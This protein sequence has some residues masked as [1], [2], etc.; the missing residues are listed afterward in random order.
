M[1][2]KPIRTAQ[3]VITDTLRQSILDGEFKPGD[4]LIQDEIADRYGVSRIPVREAMRTLSAEGLLTFSS[5]R[6]AIVT[7]LS[8]EDIEEILSI[9]AV[10]EGMANRLAAE[11]AT[12]K[13]LEKIR[14]IFH[15]LEAAR[16]DVGLYFQCNNEFH[17]AILDAAHSPR[18]KELITNLRNSVEPVA[19]RFL[20][21]AGRVEIAHHDHL[22]I[23][24]TLE[25]RDLQ[26][27]ER[28]AAGHTQHV[29]AGILD[30]YRQPETAFRRNEVWDTKRGD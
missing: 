23:L 9:R 26:A 22:E 15:N 8:A 30:D 4:R 11:R 6:G 21:A 5:R 3:E 18:L 16:G 7:A 13:E 25:N 20:I 17:E 2:R 27:A 14:Q 10:L 1:D 29:L 19:R 28:V 12:E 24:E